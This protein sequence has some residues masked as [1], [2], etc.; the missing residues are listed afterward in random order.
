M[1]WGMV[2]QTTNSGGNVDDFMPVPLRRDHIGKPLFYNTAA[3]PPLNTNLDDVA[4]TFIMQIAR[5][6]STFDGQ[7][8][9]L[10][11]RFAYIVETISHCIAPS[12]LILLTKTI[13]IRIASNDV[14]LPK[15]L[16]SY[17][18]ATTK[19]Y[20]FDMLLERYSRLCSVR[21]RKLDP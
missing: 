6:L 15:I 14:E 13:V 12:H 2:S 19:I 3:K 1:D 9:S 20:G 8:T 21:R 18:V 17:S 4:S 7:D 5:N 10:I 11:G 16:V